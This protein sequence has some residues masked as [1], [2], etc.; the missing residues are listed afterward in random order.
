VSIR[1][2][3]DQGQPDPAH[4]A[5]AW[6]DA[7]TPPNGAWS[8]WATDDE[9]LADQYPNVVW[10]VIDPAEAPPTSAPAGLQATAMSDVRI[11]L[12][13]GSVVAASGYR[14]RVDGGLPVD[15]GVA[16]S[17]QVTGLTASTQYSFEVQAYN[18]VGDGPWSA[19]V[20]ETTQDVQVGGPLDYNWHLAVWADEISAADDDPLTGWNDLSGNARHLSGAATYKASVIGGRP[21]VRFNGHPNKMAVNF[22]AI[23]QPNEIVVVYKLTSDASES[24]LCDGFGSVNRHNLAIDVV[25]D[26]FQLFDGQVSYSANNSGAKVLTPRFLSWVVDG[27][28][29]VLRVDGATAATGGGSHALEGVTVGAR[30]E[31]VGSFADV[32]FFGIVNGTLT[33]QERADLMAWADSHY[34]LGL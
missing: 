27:A 14:Y 11:D 20:L 22:A 26:R 5:T 16:L 12:S 18:G 21:A 13:W 29:S 4:P 2:L 32:A 33:T 31:S 24:H 23:S 1:D 25:N 6:G 7:L 9:T 30:F 17:A 3:F 15:V 19:P 8:V 28:S 34:G 10:L